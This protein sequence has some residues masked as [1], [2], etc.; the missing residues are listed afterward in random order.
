MN[1]NPGEQAKT[2][3][4]RIQSMLEALLEFS[5]RYQI[6]LFIDAVDEIDEREELLDALEALSSRSANIRLFITSRS[7]V[8]VLARLPEETVQID[9]GKKVREMDQDIYLYINGRLQSD[10]GLA[11]PNPEIS[12]TIL[13]TLQS[14]SSGM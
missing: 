3:S 14:Q 2:A 8:Q 10:R 7:E 13:Q 4:P 1:A 5:T 6:F 11:W 9:L 12:K